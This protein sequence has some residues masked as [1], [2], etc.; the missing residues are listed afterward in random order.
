VGGPDGAAGAL[1]DWVGAAV[2]AEVVGVAVVES[3]S[4]WPAPVVLVSVPV[5]C[6]V[7][8]AALVVVAVRCACGLAES[9]VPGST[10]CTPVGVAPV[11][12]SPA[13]LT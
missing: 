6:W 1:S 7:V 9:V 4:T 5:C 8:V 11:E 10:G 3:V 2:G 13:G 12:E